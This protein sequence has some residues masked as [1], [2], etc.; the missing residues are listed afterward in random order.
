MKFADEG[1]KKNLKVSKSKQKSGLH[2]NKDLQN[3]DEYEKSQSKILLQD[4]SL[5]VSALTS[6]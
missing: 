3:S 2:F 4:S 6:V 1:K 5:N